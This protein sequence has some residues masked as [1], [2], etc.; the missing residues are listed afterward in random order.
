VGTGCVPARPRGDG[1]LIPA[2]TGAEARRLLKEAGY[3]NLSFT[4]TNRAVPQPYEPVGVWLIDQW[5]QIGLNVKQ[6]VT[7]SAKHYAELRGGNF[8]AAADFQCGY[9]V[10]PDLDLYK[11]TSKDKNAA[12]YSRYIDRELDELYEKQGRAS[13]PDERKKFV[14]EFERRLL[15]E[16]VHYIYTLQWHRIIPHNS[17]VHGWTITPSHYLN[18][19]L[20]T[21]WLSE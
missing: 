17:K 9:T 16:E 5:R 19:Q 14:R 15:D 10:E 11:F 12:N 1:G 4:L 2:G 13:S 20:D 18:Q 21:V 7:E 6:V 8:E 3:E